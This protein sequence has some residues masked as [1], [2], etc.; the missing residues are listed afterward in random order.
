MVNRKTIPDILFEMFQ[1]ENVR[2]RETEGGLFVTPVKE[3]VDRT[4]GL[5][6]MF[7]G[8]SELS[9]DDFLKTMRA[10]KELEL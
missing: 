5:R 1:T 7:A 4:V 6:G 10:E 8:R 9:V 3:K 2:V